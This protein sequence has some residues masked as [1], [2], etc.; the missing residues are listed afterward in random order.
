MD[1]LW[2]VNSNNDINSR[3]RPKHHLLGESQVLYLHQ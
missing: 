3:H 1:F 2:F